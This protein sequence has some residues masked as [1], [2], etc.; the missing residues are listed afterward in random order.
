[1]KIFGFLFWCSA[2][3]SLLLE[4]AFGLEKPRSRGSRAE[5]RGLEVLAFVSSSFFSLPDVLECS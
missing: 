1:M 3:L 4:S 2:G 5:G